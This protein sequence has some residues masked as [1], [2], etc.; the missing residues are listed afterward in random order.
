MI[1]VQDEMARAALG[2]RAGGL[3]QCTMHGQSQTLRKAFPDPRSSSQSD[4]TSDICSL[5]SQA[6]RSACFVGLDKS[7]FQHKETSAL[8]SGCHGCFNSKKKNNQ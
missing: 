4:S 1:Y 7:V 2:L 8:K 5:P 3:A 6:V